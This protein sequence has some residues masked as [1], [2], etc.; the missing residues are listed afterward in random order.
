VI[1]KI[2]YCFISKSYVYLALLAD[3]LSFMAA[4][5][6]FKVKCFDLI[7][8]MKKTMQHHDFNYLYFSFLCVRVNSL[9]AAAKCLFIKK[10]FMECGA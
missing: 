7:F 10:V 9:L 2:I 4:F 8:F 3:G 5:I 1:Y 6:F